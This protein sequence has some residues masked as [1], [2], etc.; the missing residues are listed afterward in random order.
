MAARVQAIVSNHEQLSPL[1]VRL[2]HGVVKHSM[3]SKTLGRKKQ[4]RLHKLRIC[5]TRKGRFSAFHKKEVVAET[6]QFQKVWE[7]SK[8][9]K[10]VTTWIT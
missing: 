9:G 1:Q 8:K 2:M 7:E 3:N 6:S 5:L 10:R 4:K